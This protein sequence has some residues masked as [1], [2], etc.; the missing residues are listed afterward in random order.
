MKI[1]RSTAR[2][3]VPL[4]TFALAAAA[5]GL[6]A[7]F[8]LG[9]QSPKPVES[10]PELK[11]VPPPPVSKRRLKPRPYLIIKRWM[12]I[13]I[14]FLLIV[15]LAPLMGLIALGIALDG[16]GSPIVKQARVG[17][18]VRGKG[19]RFSWET[20]SI[21]LYK[22][23]TNGALEDAEK[24]RAGVEGAKIRYLFSRNSPLRPMD[25]FLHRTR[26]DHLPT[27]FNVL[28]GDISLVGPRPA[29]PE[30]VEA[31]DEKQ[32]RR[33][34]M[35]AGMTGWWQITKP[36]TKGSSVTLEHMF[37]RDIWY[38]DNKTLRRNCKILLLTPLVILLGRMYYEYTHAR[39][40]E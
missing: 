1:S 21:T 5:T 34:E 18:R 37:E 6:L 8:A 30:E 10:T 28:K 32:L 38:V 16:K 2:K 7:T 13:G 35:P 12:D 29:T 9:S 26:F 40:A 25:A 17:A 4:L 14:S 33:L 23:R 39:E 19:G 22:F 36:I 24:A 3:F 15:I 31:Y 27:L 20:K 11:L